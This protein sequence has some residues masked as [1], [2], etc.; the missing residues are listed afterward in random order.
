MLWIRKTLRVVAMGPVAFV[1]LV[2][3]G[4]L[5]EHWFGVWGWLADPN[6]ILKKGTELFIALYENPWFTPVAIASI[7]FAAGVWLDYAAK[8]LARDAERAKL[9]QKLSLIQRIDHVEHRMG[10][11]EYGVTDYSLYAEIVSLKTALEAEGFVF[12]DA[13]PSKAQG[14]AIIS[15]YLSTLSVFLKR[16]DIEKARKAHLL[17]K[18]SEPSEA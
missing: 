6:S 2:Y 15:N 1:V 8:I 9:K 14:V 16:N 3:I 17:F 13:N 18:P 12:P 10:N 7:A 5:L 11:Y 4:A